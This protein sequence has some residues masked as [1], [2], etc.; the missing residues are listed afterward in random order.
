MATELVSKAAGIEML[1]VPYQ[2]IAVAI[3]ATLG[4]TIDV[5]FAAPTVKGQ[6]DAGALRALATTGRA[7]NPDFPNLPTL[8]EAGLP[9][10][11]ITL[12][13]GLMVPAATPE[14]VLARLRGATAEMRKD[15]ATL[16]GMRKLGYDSQYL[17]HDAFRAF[18][19]QD[20]EQWGR[21]AKSANIELTD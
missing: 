1:H 7:R 2:G 10:L 19:L 3:A 18:V 12:W 16:E 11:S 4:G 15:P 17:P 21:A 6:V 14:P 9:N 5:I 8:A 20:M 13:W